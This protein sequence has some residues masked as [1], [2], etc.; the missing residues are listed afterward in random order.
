MTN[1]TVLGNTGDGIA[2]TFGALILN[3]NCDQ[4]GNAGGNGAGIHATGSDNRID[5][6]N[7]TQA[8]RGIEANNAGNVI[9]RNTCATNTT[10]WVLAANNVFGAIVDRRA[11]AS[12]LVNGFTAASSLG[13][14]DPWANVSY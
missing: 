4:N 9:V 3:N 6:N 12:A 8:D 5:G 7:C 14:T 2:C 10:D 1:C 11:P 13:S